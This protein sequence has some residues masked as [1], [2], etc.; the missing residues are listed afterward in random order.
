MKN[1]YKEHLRVERL[2]A[3]DLDVLVTLPT[4][5]VGAE[6]DDSNKIPAQTNEV[7]GSHG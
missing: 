1:T 3:G 5:E 6:P 2:H 7:G 4:K